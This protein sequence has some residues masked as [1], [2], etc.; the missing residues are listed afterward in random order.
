MNNDVT[1]LDLPAA[2]LAKLPFAFR[3][4]YY[5]TTFDRRAFDAMTLYSSR[6]DGSTQMLGL[7]PKPLSKP[8][9]R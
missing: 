1:L 9:T 3:V 5:K 8:S 2:E 7:P 6:H 4:I